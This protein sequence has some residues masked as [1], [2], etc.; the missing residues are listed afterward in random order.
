MCVKTLLQAQPVG[1]LALP[2]VPMLSAAPA[3]QHNSSGEVRTQMQDLLARLKHGS[4]TR[5]T[6]NPRQLQH[7][8]SLVL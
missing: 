5:V 3:D 4:R 2:Q 8:H 1:K 7:V 6:L